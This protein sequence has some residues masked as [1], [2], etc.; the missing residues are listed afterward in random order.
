MSFR[1]QHACISR[2]KTWNRL[3]LDRELLH[4]KQSL[5]YKYAELVYYGLWYTRSKKLWM[6]LI[7]RDAEECYRNSAPETV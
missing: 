4:F 5:E 7:Q 2:I 1:R 6:H 3:V